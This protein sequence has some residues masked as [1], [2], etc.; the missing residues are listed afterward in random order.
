ML[1][2]WEMTLE[3]L[4]HVVHGEET[5]VI[6]HTK[7]HHK[8]PM[9]KLQEKLHMALDKIAIINLIISLVLIPGKTTQLT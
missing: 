3:M 9:V 5:A 1:K 6:P 2:F 8:D 7:L 4:L